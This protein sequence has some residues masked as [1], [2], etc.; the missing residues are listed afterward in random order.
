MGVLC[1]PKFGALMRDTLR[2]DALPASPVWV[3]S[4]LRAPSRGCAGCLV[5]VSFASHLASPRGLLAVPRCALASYAASVFRAVP[6]FRL[7][8]AAQC[9]T[10]RAACQ[11]L[12]APRSICFF[13]ARIACGSALLLWY[14]RK[15]CALLLCS[16]ILGGSAAA[17]AVLLRVPRHYSRIGSLVWMLSV[18]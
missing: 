13:F 7:F 4:R 12:A 2:P 6:R 8:N 14:S 1:A 16:R 9:S 5:S 11:A 10:F 18:R 3:P 17:P 15:P